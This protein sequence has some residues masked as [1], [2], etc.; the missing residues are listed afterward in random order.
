[1]KT[2]ILHIIFL[3]LIS[4]ILVGQNY[5]I[6]G[7]VSS[8]ENSV[9]IEYAIVVAIASNDSSLVFPT[10]TNKLG[11][12]ALKNIPGGK[13]NLKISFFG[14]MKVD[15]AINV[16]S[17]IDNLLI[18]LRVN[19]TE[20]SEVVVNHGINPVEFKI[21]KQVINICQQMNA[22]GGTAADALQTIPSVQVDAS[23]NVTLRGSSDFTVLID[24]KP[25]MMEASDVLNQIQVETI[26]SIEVITNPSV[27]YKA[28]GNTGI[29]NIITKKNYLQ[30]TEALLNLSIANGDKYSGSLLINKKMKKLNIYAGFSYSDKTKINEN[31]SNIYDANNE[32]SQTFSGT[33]G[34]RMFSAQIKTGFDFQ[35][36]SH[37]KISMDFNVGNW[38]FDRIIK[39][40]FVYLDDNYIVNADEYFSNNNKYISGNMNYNRLF[41][42]KGQ[43]LTFDF[44]CNLLENDSPNEYLENP[45]Y[46]QKIENESDKEQY[47]WKLDYLKPFSENLKFESGFQYDFKKSVYNYLFSSK[48]NESDLS[49]NQVINN[50]LDYNFHNVAVYVLMNKKIKNFN[51]QTG[52]RGE[53]VNQSLIGNN[54]SLNYEKF[55]LFASVHISTII[56]DIHNLTFSFSQRINRPNEW[57]LNQL[58]YSS[59][60][61]SLKQGNPNL[62]PE[63]TNA[64]ELD[65]FVMSKKASLNTQL[66]FRQI[67]N[68][69]SNFVIYKDEQFYETYENLDKM[70]NSGVELMVN[71]NFTKW[72]KISAGISSYYSCWNGNLSDDNI[73]KNSSLITNG[74][75][76]ST[77]T[78]TKTTTLQFMAIY[79]APSKMPQGYIDNFYYFDFIAKQQFF[80]K[81]LSL[82]IRSHNTFDTG[83]MYYT[84]TGNDYYTENWYKYEGPTFILSLSY[85]LNNFKQ[86]KSENVEIDFDSGLDH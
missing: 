67:N 55:N 85:K 62:L 77:F 15:T 57:Q 51:V 16:T 54:E 80:D 24:G 19:I 11:N 6:K 7:T 63:F 45:Y 32:L 86:R 72:M 22:S 40:E 14:F 71:Y 33:R 42:D 69:I 75:F 58:V 17:N 79:Y 49:I 27:K 76:R 2:I 21:D 37:N 44:Y 81:K 84:I 36:N 65:Y 13:Y 46:L 43:T 48:I 12:F 52:L 59:D 60:R 1:M 25:T 41:D 29:I 26:Q 56:K 50:K 82:T 83:L 39:T 53:Y 10:T 5:Q 47:R 9:P 23:G 31:K 34:I 64:I 8:I 66:F 20:L 68:S 73:L 30:G 70:Y 18:E 78:I 35:M 4:N 74:N 3:L 61:F 38:I 28:E